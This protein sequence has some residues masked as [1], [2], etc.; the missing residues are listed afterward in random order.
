MKCVAYSSGSTFAA[1]SGE[2]V[3]RYVALLH[4]RIQ[5]ARS[6]R[7]RFASLEAPSGLS[8][9]K[10]CKR[11]CAANI[12]RG[13]SAATRGAVACCACTNG[14]KIRAAVASSIDP[15][16]LYMTAILIAVLSN[17]AEQ[18]HHRL[19]SVAL[20]DWIVR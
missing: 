15:S 2:R 7:E 12:D 9:V 13:V 4:F 6:G 19:V 14:L 11:I 17:A 3:T 8:Q 1:M 20:T 10:P 5:T 16:G 18:V